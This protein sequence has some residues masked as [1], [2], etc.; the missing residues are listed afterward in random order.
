MTPEPT[1]VAGTVKPSKSPAPAT[2]I[3]TTA[4]LTRDAASMTADDSSIWTACCGVVVAVL[5]AGAIV[6]GCRSRAPVLLSHRTVPPD[7]S[8]AVRSDVATIGT[9][10]PVQRPVV[11]DWRGAAAD[12]GEVGP[13]SHHRSAG[14]AVD[15]TWSPSSQLAGPDVHPDAGRS[16]AGSY[17]PTSTRWVSSSAGSWSS[18]PAGCDGR[19][20]MW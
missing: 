9:T 1:P 12:E 2:D 11:R 13:G 5:A 8:T 20:V 18:G 4:G 10:T 19:S 14:R 6:S 17:R 16:R 3:R 7:A 15:A